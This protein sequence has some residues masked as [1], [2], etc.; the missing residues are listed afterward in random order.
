MTGCTSN[1]VHGSGDRAGGPAAV[2][3]GAAALPR[4]DP[5]AQTPPSRTVFT[6]W[7]T[8][9]AS[10]LVIEREPTA[11]K[12]G[13]RWQSRRL[14][15][16][17]E[18]AV[19]VDSVQTYER[20]A[21]GSVALAEEID[22]DEGVDVV[23]EPP[24]LVIP[25]GLAPGTAG[26]TQEFRMRVYPKGDRSHIRRQGPA[27]VEIVAAG[28]EMIDAP[29]GKRVALRI[30]STLN[31]DLAPAKVVNQTTTYYVDGQ[32]MIAERDHERTTVM[33]IPVRNNR[34]DWMIR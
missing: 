29:G 21:D 32:G 34:S 28:G 25:A 5:A 1:N 31:A 23:F 26:R 18:G 24:M 20:M 2:W 3:M 27:K 17:S 8:G 12:P 16:P 33:G 22:E 14:V 4:T 15:G 19:K 30:D 13:G 9:E 6:N 11:L 7:G 10:V